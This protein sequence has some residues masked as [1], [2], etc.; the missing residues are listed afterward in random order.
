MMKAQNI[1]IVLAAIAVLTVTGCTPAAAPTPPLIDTNWLLEDLQ[2]QAAMSGIQVTIHFEKDKFNG[3]DGCNQYN[4]SYMLEGEKITINKNIATTRMACEESIMEQASAYITALTQAASYKITGQQ[5]TLL[6]VEG[7]PLTV[8]A[9][10]LT[11]TKS[12]P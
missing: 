10:D 12:N 3:T 6:D 7:K 8:F 5:L 4:G 9:Q 2:G 11:L 1:L